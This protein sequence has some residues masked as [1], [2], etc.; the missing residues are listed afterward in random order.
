[1]AKGSLESTKTGHRVTVTFLR[2]QGGRFVKIATKTVSV[3]SIGD[4]DGDGKTDGSYSASFGRPTSRGSYK[5][6]ARFKGTATYKPCS[7]S[8][9]F[10]LPA[11]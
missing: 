1:M 5:F 11:M 4:R 2:K 9:L 8:K 3:K 7:R 10:T 6:L